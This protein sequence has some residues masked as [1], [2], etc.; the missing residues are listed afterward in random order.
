MEGV[1]RFY[2]THF[3]LWL[4]SY[5]INLVVVHS[6]TFE[7]SIIGNENIAYCKMIVE[8]I[9]V[10]VTKNVVLVVIWWPDWVHYSLWEQNQAMSSIVLSNKEGKWK[11]SR[12]S[13]S[14]YCVICSMYRTVSWLLLTCQNLVSYPYR[15][16]TWFSYICNPKYQTCLK[17]DPR[18][19]S[20]SQSCMKLSL[21]VFLSC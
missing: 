16:R 14:Q 9:F 11:R 3:Y 18:Q 17:V 8:K 5:L 2:R 13:D 6:L 12:A 19:G 4:L 21:P 10:C 15:K 1:R 7:G 20:N